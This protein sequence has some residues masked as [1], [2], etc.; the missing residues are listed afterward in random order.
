MQK[1]SLVVHKSNIYVLSQCQMEMKIEFVYIVNMVFVYIS[2]TAGICKT[3]LIHVSLDYK[4]FLR[5][6]FPI[7]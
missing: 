3:L 2:Y 1:S 6:N 7:K 5:K 4:L